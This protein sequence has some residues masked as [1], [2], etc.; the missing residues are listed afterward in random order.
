MEVEIES[1]FLENGGRIGDI[2]VGGGV[3]YSV[4][5]PPCYKN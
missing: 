2:L 5:C 4:P 3:E 1:V